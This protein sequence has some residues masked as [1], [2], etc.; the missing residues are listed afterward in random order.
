MMFSFYFGVYSGTMLGALVEDGAETRSHHLFLDGVCAGGGPVRYIHALRIDLADRSRPADKAARRR[1][2]LMCAAVLGIIAALIVYR[3]G[4][5]AAKAHAVAAEC[6]SIMP[7]GR[8]RP[9]PMP[10]L[11]SM[12]TR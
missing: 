12:Q 6:V 9:A 5:A 10:V 11:I 8:Y 3:G 7:A 4:E 2:W 1:I